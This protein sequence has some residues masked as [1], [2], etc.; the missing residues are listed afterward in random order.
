ML[1]SAMKENDASKGHKVLMLSDHPS[2]SLVGHEIDL[3]FLIRA[4]LCARSP[5]FRAMF[6]LDMKEKD[7]SEIEVVDVS[8]ETLE[9]MIEFIYTGKVTDLDERADELLGNDGVQS[10]CALLR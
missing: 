7:A 6:S 9:Q 10:C 1:S 8:S 3:L 5:M 4:I 2:K